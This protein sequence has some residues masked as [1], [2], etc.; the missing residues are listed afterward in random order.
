MTAPQLASHL[1]R[2][3]LLA[4]SVDLEPINTSALGVPV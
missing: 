4:P 2:G 1:S 3:L